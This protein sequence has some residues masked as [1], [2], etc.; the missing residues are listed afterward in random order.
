ML[1]KLKINFYK[2]SRNPKRK[3]EIPYSEISEKLLKEHTIIINSSPLGTFPNIDQKPSIPYQ[4][5]TKKHLL[6]DLIYNPAETAFLIEGK[7]Q[8]AQIKNGFEMLELQAE[9]SWR[10]WNK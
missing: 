9:E 8:G 10:I 5:L 7:K 2:V 4:F 6:F 3:D 1:E